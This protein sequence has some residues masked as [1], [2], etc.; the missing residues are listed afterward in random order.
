MQPE[1][2]APARFMSFRLVVEV[3]LILVAFA[4]G[5]SIPS[6]RLEALEERV[7]MLE[8]ADDGLTTSAALTRELDLRGADTRG[9]DSAELVM[10]EFTDFQCAHCSR[11]ALGTLPQIVEKYVDTGKVLLAMRHFPLDANQPNGAKQATAAACA[12]EQGRF[13]EVHDALFAGVVGFDGGEDQTIARLLG[14]GFDLD[15]FRECL[16]SRG[17]GR[18][19]RDLLEAQ[20]LGVSGT[21]T[22]V[23]GRRVSSGKVIVQ[24]SIAGARPFDEIAGIIEMLLSVP[25]G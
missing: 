19:G 12:A 2:K 9:S 5:Y 14:R 13:W 24:N 21:P 4:A 23:F 7:T 10:L 16:S 3:V 8:A 22:F 1:M 15:R 18:V 11:F 25:T 17:R 6:A 20:E